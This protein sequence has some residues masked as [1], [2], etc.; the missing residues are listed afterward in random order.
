MS[1]KCE[2]INVFIKLM[3]SQKTINFQKKFLLMIISQIINSYK[4]H[5]SKTFITTTRIILKFISFNNAK[6]ITINNTREKSVT[7]ILYN[8]EKP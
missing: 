3:F 8:N 1:D 5:L 7:I 2:T 4:K 6:F